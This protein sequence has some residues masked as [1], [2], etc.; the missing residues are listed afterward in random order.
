MA[1]DE[2]NELVLKIRDELKS[3]LENHLLV[4]GKD[5]NSTGEIIYFILLK[6]ANLE[7]KILDLQKGETKC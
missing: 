7:N 1:K 6:I 5:F 2:Y 3:E 4:L